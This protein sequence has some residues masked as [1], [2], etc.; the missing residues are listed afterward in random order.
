MKTIRKRIQF[1]ILAL[2][3]LAVVPAWSQDNAEDAPV[4]VELQA[5]LQEMGP[6]LESAEGNP[7]VV[8][9]ELP[10]L[11]ALYEKYS[12][13]KSMEVAR[14]LVIKAMLSMEF[15]NDPDLALATFKRLETDFA[16]T[17]IEEKARAAAEKIEIQSQLRAGKQFPSFAVKNLSGEPLE[18]EAYRGKV[19]LLDF[20]ATWC[21]PCVAEL[22]NVLDTYEAYHDQG[23][24]IIGIS[25]DKSRESLESFTSEKGMTWPQYFDG[26]GWQNALAQ[27]YGIQSIPATFLLDRDGVIIASGLRGEELKNTV[28]KALGAE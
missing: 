5:L 23:F 6:K 12:G 24:E 2:L 19:V 22:P 18:L 1:L 7:E 20:W 25:L 16:G 10:K 9:A 21:G 11:D 14:I 4:A 3:A 15:L 28:A 27:K 13:D 26:E 8:R 17:E